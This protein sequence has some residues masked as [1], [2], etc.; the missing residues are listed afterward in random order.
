M[1]NYGYGWECIYILQP[2]EMFDLLSDFLVQLADFLDPPVSR[3]LNHSYSIVTI[4]LHL[5]VETEQ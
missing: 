5:A 3:I 4:I 2:Q 1:C